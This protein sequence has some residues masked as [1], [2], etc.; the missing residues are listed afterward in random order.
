LLLAL[1]AQAVVFGLG[2]HYLRNAGSSLASSEG[3]ILNLLVGNVELRQDGVDGFAGWGVKVWTEA[4][5]FVDI[6]LT[7][8]MQLRTYNAQLVA[9]VYPG[10][11][12][13]LD[14]ESDT[15]AVEAAWGI[16]LISDDTTRPIFAQ[17]SL[18]LS[19]T[20]P[21]ELPPPV[22]FLR[23]FVG[24]GLDLV[25]STPVLNPR[26]GTAF[27]TRVRE[28]MPDSALYENLRPENREHL[29]G[30]LSEELSRYWDEKGLGFGVGGHLMA[31][32]RIAGPFTP[33]ALYAN[34]KWHFGGGLDAQFTQGLTVDAGGGVEF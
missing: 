3:E 34:G 27:I 16:P 2:A 31:G 30:I 7:G 21:F 18:E 13:Q 24:A 25:W 5:P 17:F 1:Q 26:F 33:L 29:K 20:Y 4:V 19:A 15:I 8:N 23:P 9:S 22:S 12:E 14:F 10:F 11:E 6:E 32:L 28:T